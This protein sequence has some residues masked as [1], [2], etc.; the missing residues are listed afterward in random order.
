MTPFLVGQ[1][2]TSMPNSHFWTR[3]SC[4]AKQTLAQWSIGQAQPGGGETIC[5]SPKDVVPK[6][7]SSAALNEWVITTRSA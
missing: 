4:R 5:T 3:V 7:R 6:G 1:A 2:A